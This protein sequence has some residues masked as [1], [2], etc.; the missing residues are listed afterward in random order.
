MH[1]WFDAF[2]TLKLIHGLRD[3]CLPTINYAT[4]ETNQAFTGLLANDQELMVFHQQ[5]SRKLSE[6]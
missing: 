4:L 1:T 6:S 3:S 2:R 5:L